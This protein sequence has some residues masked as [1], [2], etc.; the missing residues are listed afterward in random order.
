MADS[1]TKEEYAL[2]WLRFAEMDFSSAEYLLGHRPLPIEIICYHCQQSAE[3]WLKGF[4]VMQDIRPP[5]TH[6]LEELYRLCESF[7]QNIQNIRKP[8]SVLTKYSVQPRYPEEM[9]ITEPEMYAALNSVKSI[10]EFMRPLFPS[11]LGV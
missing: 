6:N 2:E 11:P 5:K 9:S 1:M 8:C 7:N 4:L 3:K 10:V